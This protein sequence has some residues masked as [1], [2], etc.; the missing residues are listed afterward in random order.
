M[1]VDD[2][3]RGDHE[4]RDLGRVLRG[5]HARGAFGRLIVPA[6]PQLLLVGT[7]LNRVDAWG[8]LVVRAAVDA[9]LD[10]DSGHTVSLVEPTNDESWALMSDL[11]GSSLLPSRC[12]WAGTRALAPRGSR[13]LV[14]TSA[15]L[16]Q[17]DVQLVVDEGL[18]RATAALGYGDR[19]GHALQE[20]AAV[21]LHNAH[22]HGAASR[23]APLVCATFEAQGNDLQ[24]VVL[25]LGPG[26][27]AVGHGATALREAV[28]SSRKNLSSLH[29]L[30]GR[31][32]GGLQFS[33]RLAWGTGRAAFRSGGSWRFSDAAELPGFMAGLEIHR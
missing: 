27:P 4:Q 6:A 28:E 24:V 3:P 1:S 19:A 32:R 33:V 5:Q 8:G 25:D 31:K 21:F 10:A 23:I 16:D 7:T 2:S 13:V 20:A 9:H 11:L 17:E 29:G 30:T 26:Q 18:R 15:I 14:P 12:S 22:T